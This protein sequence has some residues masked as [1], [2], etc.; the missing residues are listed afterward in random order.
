M[1]FPW[2]SWFPLCCTLLVWDCHENFFFR[3]LFP[4]E[5]FPFWN[6][7]LLVVG[8][9][10]IIR[11]CRRVFG[12]WSR[13][14]SWK[15]LWGLYLGTHFGYYTKKWKKWTRVHEENMKNTD[16]VGV[17][18]K[19]F[20]FANDIFFIDWL[21]LKVSKP[22]DLVFL[23]LSYHFLEISHFLQC[24]HILPDKTGKF[25]KSWWVEVLLPPINKY[26]D[27][28][29]VESYIVW[30]Y[31]LPLHCIVCLQITVVVWWC[32]KEQLFNTGFSIRK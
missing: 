26:P 29:M 13:V 5:T 24:Q 28:I 11:V 25:L 6:F 2:G 32:F 3:E 30:L 20:L 10:V 9:G 31:C 18:R 14:V 7:V 1:K 22:F 19:L 8:V 21:F 23:D 16:K 27:T 12:Y 15:F 4:S 17:L